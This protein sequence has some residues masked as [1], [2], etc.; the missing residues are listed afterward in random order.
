MRAI[1]LF[2][3]ERRPLRRQRLDF[4]LER[5]PAHGKGEQS[6]R[7]AAISAFEPLTHSRRAAA[8]AT[9]S[10]AASR[11]IASSQEALP[12]ALFQEA[13]AAAQRPLELADARAMA[14]VDRQ[15][16]AVEETP[17]LA[18][19]AGEQ[20]I[21][22]R[23]QPDDAQMSVKA[24]DEATGARSMRSAPL[25]RRR[26]PGSSRSRA[27]GVSP[28][29]STSIESAKPPAPPIRA[30]SAS[31][32]RLQ[33]P[34]RRQ[35]RQSLEEIGLAGAVLAAQ[36]D[37]AAVDRKIERRIG[38]EIVQHQA[39]HERAPRPGMRPSG[40]A[41]AAACAT[42][43]ARRKWAAA[44]A[45]TVR[46][47]L[48][49]TFDVLMPAEGMGAVADLIAERLPLHRLWLERDPDAWFATWGPKIRAVASNGPAAP[50]DAAFMG[51]LP[52]LEIVA[53]FGVGYDHVD[54][55]WAA[56]H[57]I[58]VTH[59]PGVLDDEVAELAMAL[60]V[61]AVRRLPQAERFLRA[62]EWR[63][64]GFPL[65]ASLRGR[66]MGILGLGRIG[67]A[68]AARAQELSASKSS[69]TAAARKPGVAYRFYPSLA[70]MAKACDIL[71]V[72]APGGAGNAPYRRRRAARRAGAGRGA[73][74]HRPRLAGRRAGPDRGADERDNPRRRP[75][76]LRQRAGGSG[77]AARA[78]QCGAAAPCRL[79][80]GEDAERDGR[81]RGAEPVRLVG[82]RNRR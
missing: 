21:H 76:R 59:T 26:R 12:R 16:E 65:S 82:R 25:R 8:T 36:D 11:S 17:P 24:R 54:A 3:L 80:F 20:R 1:A 43:A 46:E 2:G 47:T 27:D 56:A 39:P 35:Q 40:L 6:S 71:M 32:A 41:M 31:S 29:S 15:H 45:A 81:M 34:A 28:S 10:S 57:G 52:N 72:A 18:R 37:E 33:A 74:Q 64:G 67:K 62:G 66:T 68:I 5:E 48:V 4:A 53:S 70:A 22:R 23:R 60:T 7:S 30:H 50:I 14:G 73:H 42:S 44:L 38:A 51:R 58:V 13:V 75:R 61:M 78:R 69:I 49:T 9:P 63:K 19:R 77:R 55:K 79:G